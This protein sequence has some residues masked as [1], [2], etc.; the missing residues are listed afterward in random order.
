[1]ISINSSLNSFFTSHV[2]QWNL[3]HVRS[4]SGE[5]PFKSIHIISLEGNQ[6]TEGESPSWRIKIMVACLQII[7]WVESQTVG[8]SSL[9]SFCPKLN[10][11]NQ[12]MIKKFKVKEPKSSQ[13]KLGK[14]CHLDRIWLLCPLR[15]LRESNVFLM[16]YI[17]YTVYSDDFNITLQNLLY[18]K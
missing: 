9:R 11:T 2:R 16:T 1:M 10:P 14:I 3:V 5:M 7:L 4:V 12:R 15:K 17:P 6:S 8:N 13:R 18:V